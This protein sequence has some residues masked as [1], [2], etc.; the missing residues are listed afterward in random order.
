MADRKLLQP[1][2][3]FIN[4]LGERGADT[5]KK[6]YQCATC[7]VVC[8]ISPDN[9]PFPRKEMIAASWGLSDELVSDVDVWLCHQCGDCSAKCPRGARPGDV[10][11]SIRS[12]AIERYAKPGWLARMVNDPKKL[13]LLVLFPT[14]LF[15]VVGLITGLLDFTPALR[16]GHISHGMFF[17]SWLVDIIFV[18]SL[19]FAVAVFALAL[20]GFVTDM[21]ENAVRTGKVMKKEL[22]WMDMIKSAPGVLLTILRHDKFSECGENK[23]RATTHMMVLFG[24]IGLFIVTGIFFLV[25]YGSMIYFGSYEEAWHS[26]Y[27]QLNPVKWLANVSGLAL[28][29]GS[30]VMAK[31]RLF[32]DEKIA[33][34]TYK[35]WFL[36]GLVFGLAVTGLGTELTRLAGLATDTYILYFIH[37]IFVFATFVY[38]PY[39]KLAHLVYRTVAMIYADWAGREEAIKAAAE[40]AAKAEPSAA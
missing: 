25:L 3:E 33:K 20:K 40:E 15:I 34:S 36:I 9:K 39:S 1:D 31:N 7:S 18:P 29:V 13:P 11:G 27:S 23:D 19:F 35:D 12:L 2:V 24:F 16:H 32:K 30:L 38:T 6:C 8:P 37:L 21:H 28:L 26:P 5:L 4:S 10:L 17:S 14:V 22:S